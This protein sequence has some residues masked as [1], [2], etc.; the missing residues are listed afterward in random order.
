MTHT[1]HLTT[2]S[3]GLNVHLKE[4][5]TA[6]IISTWVWY[7]VGS[8]NEI[9]GT[10]GISHWVEHMQ[11][12]GTQAFPAGILDREISRVGGVWNALTHLDW[13]TYF[14]T[15]PAHLFDIS[16]ALEADRMINSQYTPTEVE[17][18][19]TVII[20]EREGNENQP[21]FLLAEAV[22]GAAFTQHP[23]QHEVIGL[24]EDLT[25]ITCDDLYDH[26][27][28]YYQPANALVAIAGDFKT[29]EMLEKIENTFGTLPPGEVINDEVENDPPLGEEKRAHV[30]GPGET[31]YVQIAY[32]APSANNP[33]FFTL[34]ILDSLLTGPTSLNMFGS[35]GTSNKTSRL[36]RALVEGEISVSCHG[37]L[38]ATLDPYLYT[39]NLTVHPA[40]TPEEVLNA[41]DQEIM[42]VLESPVTKAE[43]DRAVKQAKALFA[44]SAE[45]ISNQAFWLGYS[46]MFASYD[47]FVNYVDHIAQVTPEK[48]LQTAQTYLNPDNRVVG[49]YTPGSSNIEQ[50]S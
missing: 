46:E 22:Q 7:R 29:A 41:V 28:R 25:K 38:Q 8:R 44:F 26:Y 16:L 20:S 10:T 4:I 37:S 9:R 6:P 18:E 40:H 19:R 39:I 34:T 50:E 31:S 27:R 36:Y 2:L 33:D 43:I 30:I 14:E 42:R 13:T 49:F 32:R 12:K 35:G 24:K 15:M 48:V 5:H 23:Y 17:R 21:L 3:N 11:F 1:P 47:W 45:N